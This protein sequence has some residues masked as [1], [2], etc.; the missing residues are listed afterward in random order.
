MIGA[1]AGGAI[2]VVLY[3]INQSTGAHTYVGRINISVPSSPAIV[4]TIRSIKVIDSGTTGWKIYIIASG[5][6]LVG[7][8]GVLLANSI[9]RS[10]F[11]QVSPPLIPFAT[12]NNQ[13]AVYQLGRLASLTSRSFTITLGT[14][15]KFA[16]TAHGFANNDQVY[17][18]SQVGPAWT[19]ATFVV[20]T[21]Y[22]VRNVSA[23]DFELAATFNGASIAAQI[24]YSDA[25]GT[26]LNTSSNKFTTS[27]VTTPPSA[28]TPGPLPLFGAGA[29]FAFSR[30][31][32]R[33]IAQSV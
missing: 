17:F 21:K 23:N 12:G 22:F 7:G 32:R 2:P 16:F 6:I 15:V 29:A 9:N 20:N 18:T 19:A 1:V 5:T 27:A 11:S 24:Q 8:S 26:N 4:H 10:D 13:K 25:G 30:S 31:M 33:R 14:P 28:A 3:E